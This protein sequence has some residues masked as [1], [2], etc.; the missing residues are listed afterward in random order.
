[1]N[2][3]LISG[4]SGMVGTEITK[5]LL[6]KGVEVRWLSTRKNAKAEGVKVF[7]WDPDQHYIEE[8]ALEGVDTVIHLAGASVA[9]RWTDEHKKAI[10]DSRMKGSQT[11]FR[12]IERMSSRPTSFISASAVG[13]YPS[14]DEKLYDEKADPANDFLG[15]VVQIWEEEVDRIEDLNVRVAKMRIGI[16]LEKSGGALGQMLPAFKLGVGSPLGNGRQWMPWIHVHDLAR[17]FVHT[18]ENTSMQGAFNAA[19]ADQVRNKEF[20]RILAKVLGVPYFFPNV[21]GWALKLL[22]GEMAQIALMSTHVSVEK[23][24]ESGF[25]WKYTTLESALKDSLKK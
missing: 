3:V 24:K 10:M 2:K 16:V 6:E 18:A 5:I 7:H 20:G 1:M 11:L 15:K 12:G 25:T 23:V 9:K 14:D 19:A 8:S 13:Y 17:M 22:L 21:P 4:G